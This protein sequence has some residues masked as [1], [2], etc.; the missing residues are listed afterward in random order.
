M[1]NNM[2]ARFG[3]DDDAVP[4]RRTARARGV[5]TALAVLAA[6][7]PLALSGPA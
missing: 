5:L 2:R 7:A 4:A 6:V 3:T 1:D